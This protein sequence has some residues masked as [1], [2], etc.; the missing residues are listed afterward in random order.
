MLYSYR[1]TKGLVGLV[2]SYV[3][4]HYVF[5]VFFYSSFPSSFLSLVFY[6]IGVKYTEFTSI[7]SLVCDRK[8]LAIVVK[9][10]VKT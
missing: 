9:Y 3:S 8:Y 10:I 2:Y 7:D 6:I 4:V 1:F 5:R